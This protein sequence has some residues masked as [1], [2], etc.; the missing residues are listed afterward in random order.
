MFQDNQSSKNQIS[1]SKKNL[2]SIDP[3][4]LARE[5]VKKADTIKKTA[6][7]V[8][9]TASYADNFMNKVAQNNTALVFRK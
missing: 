6:Q 2:E 4:D 1:K 7:T 9:Q 3:T 8:G 5:T